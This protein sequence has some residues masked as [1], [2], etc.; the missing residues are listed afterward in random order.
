MSALLSILFVATV[1][2]GGATAWAITALYRFVHP[3]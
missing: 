2:V 1:A 3:G